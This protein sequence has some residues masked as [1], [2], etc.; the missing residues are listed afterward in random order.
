MEDAPSLLILSITLVS[1]LIV[2]GFFSGSETGMMA[3]N[4]IKLKN[5]SKKSKKSAKRA[6]SLLKRPDQLLSAILVG[7]NFANILASAIVTIIM[8][9]YFGGNVLLGSIILTVVILIFSEIT[10]KTIATIKPESFATKSSFILKILVTLFKPIIFF[11]NFLSR[12]I[13][14]IFKLDAKDATLND[15]LNTEELRTLLEESGELIPKQ[16]RK[17]LSSVLGMEELIV[18][19]IMIPTSEIIGIDINQ[20]Y[21]AATKT[22][23]STY[24][25]RLPVF[26]GSIDNLVGMLHLK[27]SHSFL[28]QFHTNSKDNLKKILKETYFVSQSTLLMKQLRE[29]LANNQSIALVV[30][31]YGEIEGLISVEDIFKEITG[32]F[33]GDKEELEK[34]F[35]QQKDGSILT[36]GNSKIRD[37]NNYLGWDIVEDGSKTING[38]ITEYLD[39]IPQANLCIEIKGYR[40]EVLELDENLISKIKISKV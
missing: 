35:F 13:L 20:S 5:L 27:D 15:N 36:D 40:F 21:E 37:L 4:K 2:S 10:P 23:E 33:G 7:N 18:E 28:E 30:D 17:M 38:L 39:Q 19:D 16:Y 25:T 12:L 8:I 11:T 31:E 32:K 9:N 1:L 29:F 22:I 24:Y 34:E 6:L 3:A 14:R 26:D